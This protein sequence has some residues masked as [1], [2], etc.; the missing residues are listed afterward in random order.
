MKR[1]TV[2][3]AL[4]WLAFAIRVLSLS[5]QSVWWDEAFTWQTTSHGGDAL[6]HMLQTGDR[7]PPLY[8]VLTALWGSLGG[9]SEFSLRFVPL[10]SGLVGVAMLF[11]LARRLFGWRAGVWTLGLAAIKLPRRTDAPST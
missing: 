8:F 11:A 4:V 9:W 1:F 2:I 3:I 7:N 5:S 10:A 6:W